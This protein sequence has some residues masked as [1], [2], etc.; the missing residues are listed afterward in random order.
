MSAFRDPAF[1]TVT[2]SYG[3]ENNTHY[4]PK[5]NIRKRTVYRLQ[6]NRD[7]A[8]GRTFPKY[9]IR[10][11]RKYVNHVPDEYMTEYE[12]VVQETE[13]HCR[14]HSIYMLGPEKAGFLWKLVVQTR[15]QFVV[16]CGTAIG[17][18]GLHIAR[19]LSENGTGK[20]VTIEIDKDRSIQAESAFKKAGLGHLIETLVGEAAILLRAVERDVDFLFL[21]NEYGNYYRC[22]RAIEGR[23]SD[24]A[25]IVA[26]N[27]LVGA[28]AMKDYLS[29][30][31]DR[32]E[33]K[34]HYFETSLPWVSR[35]A[36][37]VSVHRTQ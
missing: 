3:R 31:R 23:L 37:E 29:L 22:F 10:V 33:S 4:G 15:P 2:L 26:D 16:E 1:E 14:T 27:V 35:D 17:Y 13:E 19:A 21:D 34:T 5:T 20:L 8:G 28:Y 11:L 30:V 6:R 18:S 36:M 24:G 12:R 32:Y 25:V 9:E 7:D